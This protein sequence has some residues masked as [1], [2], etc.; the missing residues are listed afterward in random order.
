MAVIL[1][2]F[3]TGGTAGCVVR[4]DAVMMVAQRKEIVDPLSN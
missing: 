2:R 3:V 1:D 4:I